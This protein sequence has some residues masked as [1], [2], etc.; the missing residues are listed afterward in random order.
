MSILQQARFSVTVNHLRDLPQD[1]VPEVAFAGRSN[2]GKSTALNVLCQQKRLAF[3][4]KTPGRTQH[5]NFFE[6]SDKEGLKA[7]LVD[8]P[9]YGYA[10][11]GGGVKLHWEKLLDDYIQVRGHLA[12]LVLLMDARRPFTELDCQMVEWYQ[13][14][15]KPLLVLLTK[16]DK[17][18]RNEAA[19]TLA[20][21]RKVLAEY[22]AQSDSQAVLEARLFSATARI[23]LNEAAQTVC[24]WLELPFTPTPEGKVAPYAGAA[25]KSAEKKAAGQSAAKPGAGAKPKAAAKPV[26]AVKTAKPKKTPL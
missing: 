20:R 12:G 3:A 21:A 5:I 16:A 26:K 24:A 19:Q 10:E 15:G 18:T 1:P 25:K 17:L 22:A 13:P 9:G 4:S 8:L 6:I 23:G 2:A 11:V 14:T 7:K